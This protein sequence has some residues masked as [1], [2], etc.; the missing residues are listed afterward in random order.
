MYFLVILASSIVNFLFLVDG[1]D[2]NMHHI[3]VAHLHH[4]SEEVSAAA[5]SYFDYDLYSDGFMVINYAESI[6][7]ANHV[8][9]E[10][11]NASPGTIV[12]SWDQTNRTYTASLEYKDKNKKNLIKYK[13]YFFDDSNTQYPK[14]FSEQ[15]FTYAVG[16]PTAIAII[17]I[18]APKYRSIFTPKNIIVGAAYEWQ[19]R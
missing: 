11:L 10:N 2:Y 5:L 19:E 18:G 4:V 9:I 3:K 7:Q 16:N 17:D 15:G 14:L 12:E 13:I 8:L 1:Q 6:K